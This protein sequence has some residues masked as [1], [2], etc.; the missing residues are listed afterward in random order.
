MSLYMGGIMYIYMISTR[1]G[2]VKE[3]FSE[4]EKDVEKV[5]INRGDFI[6]QID[7]DSI[8]LAEKT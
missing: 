6:Y 1:D 2:K 5:R 8:Y 7:G 4:I 3:V